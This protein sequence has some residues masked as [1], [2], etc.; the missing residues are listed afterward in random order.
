MIEQLAKN[1]QELKKE[2]FCLYDGTSNIQE[3]IPISE[4]A[5]FPINEKFLKLLDLFAT[6]NPIYYNSYNQN[7]LGINNTIH[8]GDINEYWLGS[9]SHDSSHAPFSPTWILSAFIATL[10]AKELGFTEIIDVGSG[11]G[12]I[13][14]CAKILGLNSY[15]IEIDSDLVELQKSIIKET[16]L[17]FNPYCADVTKFDFNSLKLQRPIFFI[18]GLAQMGGT[19][20][21]SSIIDKVT[22]LKLKKECLGFA[23]AGTYSKKYANSEHNAGWGELVE[24]NN[25]KIIKTLSLPTVWTFK[26]SEDTP[27]IYAK[28]C[29]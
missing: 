25:M 22:N 13:A 24:K 26:E 17:D 28:L 11:D 3:A 27:Y 20:L 5:K 2:F 21:A 4:S 16:K 19:T 15:S 12:R 6:K 10:Q 8:E 14:Y 9:I 7:I 29:R 23:F 18:G 1:L